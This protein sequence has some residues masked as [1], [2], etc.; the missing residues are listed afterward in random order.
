MYLSKW[1]NV[2]KQVVIC[3]EH[4]ESKSNE[5]NLREH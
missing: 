4:H 5:H 1:Y 3:H 2:L